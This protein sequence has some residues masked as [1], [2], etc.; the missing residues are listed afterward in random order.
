MFESAIVRVQ[1]TGKVSV[2]VGS[3]SHG[4][5]HETTFSQVVADH[6]GIPM[7]DVDIIHG[8]TESVPFGMGTYGSRSL[9]VGGSAIVRSLEKVKEKG[10]KIAARTCWKRPRRTWNSPAASGRYAVPTSRWASATWR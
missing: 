5:G 2:F 3:H 1:P 7:E 4:Q 8:D 9:A 6:L 10:A